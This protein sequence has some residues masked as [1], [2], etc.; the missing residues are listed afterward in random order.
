MKAGQTQFD[1]D[2]LIQVLDVNSNDPDDAVGVVGHTGKLTHPFGDQPATILGVWVDGRYDR[3][4]LCTGDRIKLL[5]TGEEVI[6]QPTG[7][8][9]S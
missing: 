4:G 7:V 9:T 8:L 1:V 5:D 6:V 3:F 2:T